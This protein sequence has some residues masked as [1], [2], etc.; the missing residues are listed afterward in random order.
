MDD[1]GGTTVTGTGGSFE[2]TLGSG[3]TPGAPGHLGQALALDGT[4]NAY[5]ETRGAVLDTTRGFTVSAWVN[6]ADTTRNRAAVSANGTLA[7]RFAVGLLAGKWSMWTSNQDSSNYILEAATSNAPVV[8]DQWTHLVGVYDPVARTG[9]VYVNGVPGTPTAMA[10]TWDVRGPLELGRA[11]FFGNMTDPWKGSVDEVRLWD[12]NLSKAEAA[13]VAADKQLTTGRPA[14][15]VWHLDGT[16][17]KPVGISETD[18]LTAYNGVAL[19]RPGIADKAI[20]LDGTD[21][22]LRGTRPQVDGSRDFSVS[23]WVKLPAPTAGDTTP[24]MAVTQIGQHNNEFSLYYSPYWKRWI[25]GRYKEDTSTDTLV[26][27]W[28]PDCTP[29]T[30]INGV[31]CFAGTTGEWTHLLGVSD[32][33]A[34]KLRLY[35]NGYLVGESDYTQ[36]APWANPGP[37]QVGAVN[38]EGANGEFFGGDIDDVR[39]YD[40]VVTGPEATAMVQQ[41]PQLAGRWRLDAATGT[42]AV[43]P[44]EGPAKVGAELGGEAKINPAGGNLL[45]S[46]TLQ[47]DGTTGYAAAAKSPLHTGQSFTLAGWAMTAGTP[48]RDMTVL[49]VAGTRNSAVTVRWHPLGPDTNGQQIGEWQ[50]EVRA[51]DPDGAVR[52]RTAHTAVNGT[53]ADWT[54]LAVSYDAFV[55]RLVL[56]VNGQPENQG[57]PDNSAGCIPHVSST[58][59]PQPYEA[60]GGLQ[61]GRNRAG[62]AWGEYFSG[63]LDDVWLYQGVLS[64][65]QI[66]KLADYNAVPDTSTGV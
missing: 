54:H 22:Y 24:K 25:F 19:G 52:T 35:I 42:P 66:V 46:G 62:G 50:A 31:P 48:T 5:A 57:C 10:G 16:D 6:L 65:A 63:E 14:K 58:G 1:T 11:K 38:R 33:A 20:H 43:T 9:T 55:D 23:T 34:K 37:L 2:T 53:A 12:R 59:A 60:S 27:T 8:T 17:A 36:N 45:P 29:N 3:A 18:D 47:L 15:A 26:R 28:Q 41:R 51:D 4:P 40:R 64:P 7:T 44:D 32:T 56:Y 49:S 30:P 39:I 21:D 13:D 61:F